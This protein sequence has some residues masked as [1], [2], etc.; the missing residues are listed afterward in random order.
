M[1]QTASSIRRAYTQAFVDAVKAVDPKWEP[2][3]PIPSGALDIQIYKGEGVLPVIF[4]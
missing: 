1:I 2:G 3:K 4:G